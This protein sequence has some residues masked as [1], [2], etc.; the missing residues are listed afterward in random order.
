M[1]TATLFRWS[2]VEAEQLNPLL[3]RQYISGDKAMLSRIVLTKGCKVPSHSHPHEQLAFILQ[4]SL[5]FEMGDGTTHIVNSGEILVIP[6]NLAHS[7]E[8]LEDT[9]NFDIFAPPRQDWINK[10]DAYLR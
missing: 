7:A 2:E 3:Q 9:I 5:R 1:S 6:S 4:G 10:E 8:A